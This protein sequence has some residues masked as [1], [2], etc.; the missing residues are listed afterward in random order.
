MLTKHTIA[1]G[2]LALALGL[3]LTRCTSTQKTAEPEVQAVTMFSQAGNAAIQAIRGARLAIFNGDPNAAKQLLDKAKTSVETAAKDAPMFNTKTT[4]SVQGKVIG[5]ADQE[6]KA[7]LV[8]VEGQVVQVD[9]FVLTPE[10]QGH[11]DKANEHFKKGESKQAL[12]ELHLAD[13]DV[14]YSRV[15]MP[16]SGAQNHLDAAIKL[17]NEG[18]YYEANLALKA[19]E[20]S[21]TTESVTLA[22]APKKQP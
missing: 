18:K 4:M 2:A 11:I 13:I 20:D 17:A 9:D 22:E 16:I 15:W 8:P 14:N 1:V 6:T 7:A 3:S 12:D 5:S 21:L 19:I 10:K